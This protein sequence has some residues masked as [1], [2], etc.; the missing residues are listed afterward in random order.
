MMIGPRA[1]SEADGGFTLLE[2]LLVLTL[3]AAVIVSIVPATTRSRQAVELRTAAVQLAARLNA[4]RAQATRESA[5]R[6]MLFDM[7]AARYWSP[8]L[9]RA[10][11]LPR[12]IGLGIEGGIAAAQATELRFGPDGRAGPARLALRSGSGLVRIAIDGFSGI[13]RVEG[14]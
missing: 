12:G 5:E 2:M 7:A 14:R 13:A 11:S 9:L 10:V 6:S 1:R 3:V 8:G 4:V